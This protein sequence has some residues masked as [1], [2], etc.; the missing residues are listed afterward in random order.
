VVAVLAL[1]GLLS[2]QATGHIEQFRGYREW[3]APEF[4]V[5]SAEPLLNVGVDGEALQL[6]PPLLFRSLPGALRVRIPSAAP[7]LAPAAVAPHGMGKAVT[8]LLRVLVGQQ[9][10]R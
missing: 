4:E 9:P 6:P 10:A 7:G 2:A 8:A 1:A 5:D 3:A